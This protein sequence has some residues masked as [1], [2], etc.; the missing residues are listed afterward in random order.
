MISENELELMK[1]ETILVNVSR[2]EINDEK[3]LLNAITKKT[4]S[5]AALD[6]YQ[7]E[8]YI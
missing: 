5:G 8:P 2:G 6:V 7:N 3:S 4:I 1:D